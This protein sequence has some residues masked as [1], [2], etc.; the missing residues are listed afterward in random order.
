MKNIIFFAILFFCASCADEFFDD[1]LNQESVIAISGDMNFGSVEVNQSASR[2]LTISN[3]GD[4]SFTVNSITNP[5]GFTSSYNGIVTAG[6]SIN[7][8][9]VFNPT[10]GQNYNGKIIVNA[11]NDSGTDEINCFGNGV[12]NNP[13]PIGTLKV[14]N[15]T[16]F[17][18]YFRIKKQLDQTYNSDNEIVISSG[19]SSYYY[20][21]AAGVYLYEADNSIFYASA[22]GSYSKGQVNVTSGDTATVSI[23]Q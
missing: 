14:I 5:N 2:T 4:T 12:D 10:V 23:L 8:T 18:R 20:N 21:L 6:N 22:S 15:N 13:N 16:S 7:V 3:N 1:I 17:S 19:Q 11:D 9:V